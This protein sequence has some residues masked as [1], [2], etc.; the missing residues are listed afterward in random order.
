MSALHRT[1]RLPQPLP[2]VS[3]QTLSPVDIAYETYGTLNADNSNVV[4]IC[5]AL[6]GD[7]YVAAPNPETRREAWWKT[8]VGHG[9]A[10]DLDT[11]YVICT[12][13]LGGCMGST[14]PA[15]LHPDGEPWGLRF[16]IIT[17]ADMVRAQAEGLE[18]LGIT[19][20]KAVVG[21]SMGGMQALEWAR[22]F[23][24]RMQACVVIAAT[25]RHSAQNI[26]FYLVGR[27]A[28]KAD[29]EWCAGQYSREGRFPKA[30]LGV[31]RMAAHI[32]YVSE[33]ALTRKFDRQLRNRDKVG[34][35]FD[36]DFQIE[37]YLTH[38]ANGFV[39]RF[40]ANS[41]L[42]VSRAMDYFDLAA[43]AGG[44]LAHA[45]GGCEARFAVFA[46][47]S[48]WHYPPEESRAI[49]RAL[50]AAGAH[51]S[52]LEIET[53]KGHDAFLL[54]EPGFAAALRGFMAAIPLRK[55]IP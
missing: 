23:P 47:S 39:D 25:A 1:L 49:V 44:V 21:G 18:A 26:G 24:D 38:Q 5:H 34:F 36:M 35:G 42:Y 4:L 40:D 13:V 37:S 54:D 41:Y 50:H 45:F 7:Q 11:D 12:N 51:A 16:P 22:Q 15:S 17:I 29:P 6:T 2:L 53:D 46:F 32:T 48:D 14:G 28:I 55:A 43:S 27:E 33:A 8:I 52:Y 9:R 3:G 30:G 19:H 20:L 10:I 31:A